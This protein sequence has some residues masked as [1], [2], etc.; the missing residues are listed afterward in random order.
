MSDVLLRCVGGFLVI[1][2]VLMSSVSATAS[3]EVEAANNELQASL[4]QEQNALRECQAR[5]L[6]CQRELESARESAEGLQ[7][8]QA[9]LNAC[10]EKL[11]KTFLV[12]VIQWTAGS[13]VASGSDVDLHVIDPAGNEFHYG[14]KTIASR[15]EAGELSADTTRTPGVEIWEGHRSGCR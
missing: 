3:D 13:D 11:S 6:S 14:N 9:E 10:E 1:F 5:E 15:P 12:V 8:C 7:S 2:G 4:E